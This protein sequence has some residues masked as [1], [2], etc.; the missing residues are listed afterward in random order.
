MEKKYVTQVIENQRFR[1]LAE[2]KIGGD[3]RTVKYLKII[4]YEQTYR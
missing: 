4:R 3:F 1:Q 2:S